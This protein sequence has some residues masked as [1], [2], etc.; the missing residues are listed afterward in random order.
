MQDFDSAGMAAVR[1]SRMTEMIVLIMNIALAAAMLAAMW[2]TYLQIEKVGWKNLDHYDERQTLS[3]GKAYQAGFG[4]AI[5]S[6]LGFAILTSIFETLRRYASNFL[7]IAAFAGITV[8]AVIS[9]WTDSLT[10]DKVPLRK[11][12]APCLLIGATNL[13]ACITGSE[14][15]TIGEFLA[16]EDLVG[17]LIGVSFITVAIV[18][19]ARAV[20]EQRGENE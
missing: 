9:V 2:R 4:V 5:L 1:R 19:K 3:L 6:S 18:I 13:I 15:K 8:F 10:T 16:S 17:F 12:F 14:W 11:F 7:F 20:M